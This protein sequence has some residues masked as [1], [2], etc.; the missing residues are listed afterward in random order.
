[1]KTAIT[2]TARMKSTRLP[3]KIL[4]LIN[5]IPL[6][7]QLINRLKESKLSDDI[8][9]C[10]STN[11]QDDI[12]IDYAQ[13]LDIK[14]FRGDEEDVL[15]RLYDGAM[16]YSVDFIVSMTADNPLIEPLYIDKIIE[17]FKTTNADFITALDLP[18]GCFAY[19]VKVKAM[20]F[21]LK[22]K[23]EENTEIW[24]FYF[25]KSP[26]FITEKIEV[27]EDFKHPEYRFT[28]DYP[29]DLELIREIYTKLQRNNGYFPLKDIINLIAKNP[30]LLEINKHCVQRRAPKIEQKF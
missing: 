10:T 20:E 30:E 9:L 3:L 15:K 18:L 25:Q 2:I 26:R 27:E 6:I 11:P 4:R 29:E 21:V 5:N 19:G 13:K 7:E 1:M 24:G 12:L 14:Y 8:I 28:V 17:K 22:K 16:A 23:K